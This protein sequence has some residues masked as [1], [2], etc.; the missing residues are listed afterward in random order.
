MRPSLAVGEASTPLDALRLN[1]LEG[2]WDGIS[3]GGLALNECSQ[4]VRVSGFGSGLVFQGVG[5]NNLRKW[6]FACGS[7]DPR[8]P[9]SLCSLKKWCQNPF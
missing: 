4:E 1:T 9:E 3:P 8:Q 7:G 5:L 2:V 6:G